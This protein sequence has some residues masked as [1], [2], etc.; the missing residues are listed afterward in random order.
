VPRGTIS[1]GKKLTLFLEPY[2]VYDVRLR[3]R[4]DGIASFDTTPKSVTLYPGNVSEVDWNVTPLFVLFGR[5][6]ADN[7]K[8]IGNADIAGPHGIGRTDGDGYF[9][10]EANRNDELRLTEASGA[11]CTIAIAPERSTQGLISAGDM[12]CR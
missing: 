6:V 2:K 9:Q 5:A 10:I 8:P 1:G 12:K 11:A 4:G 3:P 7:G